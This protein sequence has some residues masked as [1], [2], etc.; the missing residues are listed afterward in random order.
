LSLLEIIS[1]VSSPV[2]RPIV[3]KTNFN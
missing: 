1:L 2:Y 3:L